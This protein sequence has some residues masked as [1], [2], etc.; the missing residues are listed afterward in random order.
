MNATP[1]KPMDTG[2]HKVGNGYERTIL[3]TNVRSVHEVLPIVKVDMRVDRIPEQSYAKVY[4]WSSDPRSSQGGSWTEIASYGSMN[5]WYDMPGADRF[6]SDRTERASWRLAMDLLQ[7][8]RD[9]LM[10]FHTD[11]PR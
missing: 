7:A 4:E 9:T 8:Y 6:A 2:V 3:F 10:L 1:P 5:F 11:H